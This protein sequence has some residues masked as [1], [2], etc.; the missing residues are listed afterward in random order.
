MEA[1]RRGPGQDG[2]NCAAAFFLAAGPGSGSVPAASPPFPRSIRGSSTKKPEHLP[3]VLLPISICSSFWISRGKTK[4][5]DSLMVNA[6]DLRCQLVSS[7]GPLFHYWCLFSRV[8]A[9]PQILSRL[10]SIDKWQSAIAGL[11]LRGKFRKKWIQHVFH[12]R[13]QRM[14]LMSESRIHP[15]YHEIFPSIFCSGMTFDSCR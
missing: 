7:L 9:P 15:A 4:E 6:T 10:L 12:G 11:L 1:P 8:V 13:R 3:T 2:G 14:P 5:G